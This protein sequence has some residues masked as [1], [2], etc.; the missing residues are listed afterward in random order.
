MGRIPKAYLTALFF[1]LLLLPTAAAATNILKNTT[2]S[3]GSTVELTLQDYTLTVGTG[4]I[5]SLRLTAPNQTIILSEGDCKRLGPETLCYEKKTGDSAVRLVTYDLRAKVNLE[6][7]LDL[8][9]EDLLVGDTI[10]GTLAFNNSGERPTE[11][12]LITLPLPENLTIA[13]HDGCSF[14]GTHLYYDEDLQADQDDNCTFTI[15]IDGDV[16]AELE[17]N[18]TY[19]TLGEYETTVSEETD[20]IEATLP[21]EYTITADDLTILE[22][23]E[24]FT[25]TVFINNTLEE[26]N[27]TIEPL[28]IGSPDADYLSASNSN[29]R[30]R[31]HEGLLNKEVKENQSLNVTMR[32]EIP[33][34]GLQGEMTIEIGYYST[35]DDEPRYFQRTI[36]FATSQQPL[37]VVAEEA[38]LESGQKKTLLVTIN[39]PYHYLSM[40]SYAIEASSPLLPRPLTIREA[41]TPTLRL[42]IPL[43]APATTTTLKQTLTLDI[44]AKTASGQSIVQQE[45]IPITILPRQNLAIEKTAALKDKSLLIT[46]KATNNHLLPI[47]VTL[48]EEIPKG[49]FIKGEPGA[50]LTLDAKQEATAYTYE[51]IAEEGETQAAKLT[52]TASYTL[53]GEPMSTTQQLTITPEQLTLTT[54]QT[55]PPPTGNTTD[56]QTAPPEEPA[57]ADEDTLY[58]VLVIAAMAL[59]VI[60]VS[61]ATG[62]VRDLYLF[63]I[64]HKSILASY[65]ALLDRSR[66][67]RK[68]KEELQEDQERLKHQYHALEA[69]LRGVEQLLPKELA[70]LESLKENIAGRTRL[71]EDEIKEVDE[72]A[73]RIQARLDELSARKQTLA[74]EQASVEGQQQKLTTDKQQLEKDLQAL[75]GEQAHL[76]EEETATSKQQQELAAHIKTFKQKHAAALE[77]KLQFLAKRRE[78]VRSHHNQLEAEE[79]Y[80][81]E[82]FKRLEKDL[83]SAEQDLDKTEK[84]YKEVSSQPQP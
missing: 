14:N 77:G 78:Q 66:L 25:I 11:N 6:L 53:L 27:L 23:A 19:E 4:N 5:T 42:K 9:D 41:Y 36:P 56:N 24:P 54:P 81:K 22:P 73:K 75:L 65:Q 17:A 47:N 76:K 32:F 8:D 2:Y 31:G 48:S 16:D 29:V 15:R 35:E 52:T 18:A 67:L 12:L 50:T 21:F 46:V 62:F 45:V 72:Q 39:N 13:D 28:V 79:A 68:R 30:D 58:W 84:I 59:F 64:K 44:T 40:R 38:E 3:S 60:T 80:L 37:S 1:A 69:H 74:D 43:T 57:P 51:L 63:R 34:Y 49:F 83:A 82:E 71:L 26:E 70:S 61:F 7:T 33:S 20:T 55:P 10:E